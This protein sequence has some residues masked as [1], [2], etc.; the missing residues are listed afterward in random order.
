MGSKCAGMRTRGGWGEACASHVERWADGRR[1]AKRGGARKI[2]VIFL[3]LTGR[4]RLSWGLSGPRE[5]RPVNLSP[6]RKWSNK[7]LQA[8]NSERVV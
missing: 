6:R 1:F 3:T 7:S 5:S 2:L 4:L 8:R